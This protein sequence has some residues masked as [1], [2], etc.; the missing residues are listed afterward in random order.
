MYAGWT[1]QGEL[2]QA[3]ETVKIASYT[4]R[5]IE[6]EAVFLG[7]DSIEGA[8]IRYDQTLDGS[9]IRFGAKLLMEDFKAYGEHIQGV[10]MIVMPGDLLGAEEF[11]LANYDAEGQAKNFFAASEKI[12]SAGEY[13]TFYAVIAK[14]L[15]SNY[16]RV[17]FAR[18]YVLMENGE[19]IWT[20][21]VEYRS[22]Y[23]V[24]TAIM[25]E[26]KEKANLETWQTTILEEYLNGVA[27]VTYENGTTQLVS[28]AL[29]PVI[30][31]AEAVENENVVTLT[32]TTQKTSFAAITYNG[33]RVKNATQSYADGILTITFDK[34]QA[35]A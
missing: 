18:A 32:L 30:T 20:T 5:T 9:G 8:S 16:N 13:F 23:E 26:H 31:A 6:T 34:T 29:S 22:V 14:V 25:E 2:T 15:Q 24:A 10:G 3:G 28:S 17:F 12:V 4:K 21:K 27:N 19:Y 33:K 35:K 11:T 1:F 7:Y